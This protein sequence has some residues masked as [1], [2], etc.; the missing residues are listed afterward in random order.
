MRS[1]RL[2]D[3]DRPS[4]FLADAAVRGSAREARRGAEEGT[5]EAGLHDTIIESYM[6]DIMV[7]NHALRHRDTDLGSSGF[8]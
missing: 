6:H 4:L 3:F 1:R 8:C 5:P 2:Q 7:R